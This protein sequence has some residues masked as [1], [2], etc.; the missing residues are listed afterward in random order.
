[1]PPHGLQ[2]VNS[3]Q[4]V[5][6]SFLPVAASSGFSGKNCIS[7]YRELAGGVARWGKSVYIQ[8]FAFE[9]VKKWSM[10]L[11]T[12]LCSVV[13]GSRS[14]SDLHIIISVSLLSKSKV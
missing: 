13:T 7:A 5:T 10:T 2:G 3:W 14:G 8:T 9:T 12:H 11:G 6:E 4:I 1:M